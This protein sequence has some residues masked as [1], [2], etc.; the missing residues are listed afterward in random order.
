MKFF[1]FLSAIIVVFNINSYAETVTLKSGMVI[2]G[3]IVERGGSYI[4]VDKGKSVLKI[5]YKYMDSAEVERIKNMDLP[6]SKKTQA[7]EPPVPAA[8]S[9]AFLKSELDKAAVDIK[10]NEEQSF[11]VVIDGDFSDWKN[12]TLAWDDAGGVGHGSFSKGIDVKQVYYFNDSSYFYIFIKSDPNIQELEKKTH[13]SNNIG[14][15]YIDSDNDATTGFNK[16]NRNVSEA[17][18]GAD[19]KIWV[20]VSSY[21]MYSNGKQINGLGADYRISRSEFGKSVEVRSETSYKGSRFI[22]H[23]KDGVEMAFPLD[24]IKKEKGDTFMLTFIESSH[25]ENPSRKFVSL[26]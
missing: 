21:S 16:G 6:A 4:R 11:S 12:Y 23:G 26:D 9:D 3:E 25:K 1:L 5:K 10:T 2:E 19:I 24:I 20:P 22:Q 17:V 15:F 7:I 13:F 18:L 14:D 8:Q